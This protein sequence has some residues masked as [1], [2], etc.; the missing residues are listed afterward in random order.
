[1]LPTSL[2]WKVWHDAGLG[3]N[4][5]VLD[6]FSFLGSM[7]RVMFNQKLEARLLYT[8]EFSGYICLPLTETTKLLGY[9]CFWCARIGKTFRL[10][11]N[12]LLYA[13]FQFGIESAS[14]WSICQPPTSGLL[15]TT[16]FLTGAAS[17]P[18]SSNMCHSW[19][20]ESPQ[21]FTRSMWRNSAMLRGFPGLI[22]ENL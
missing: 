7:S 12:M 16:H 15:M 9:P 18:I 8:H 4:V 6:G 14:D 13:W 3:L 20:V 5:D 17:R 19:V 11:Y 2:Y 21:L 1:M 10:I 22:S